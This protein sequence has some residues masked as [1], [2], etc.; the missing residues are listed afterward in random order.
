MR[1]WR[2]AELYRTTTKDLRFRGQLH[3]Y[4]E[5]DYGL[6]L[7]QYRVGNCASGHVSIVERMAQIGTVTL[8][9]NKSRTILP[10]VVGL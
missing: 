10:N 4:F 6:V 1:I 8:D 3:V 9:R 7:C 5:S 2:R